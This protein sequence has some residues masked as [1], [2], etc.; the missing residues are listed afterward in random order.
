M[1]APDLPLA[2][3]DL[4]DAELVELDDL[5]AA[6]PEPAMPMEIVM[7][8]G[9]LCGVI[10]QPVL[11]PAEQWLALV[12]DIER[13]AFAQE[14]VG[15]DRI[16]TLVLRRHAALVRA[17][18]ENG[19]FDPL[20]VDDDG[21]EAD[22][23]AARGE[24]GPLA[25]MNAISRPLVPW[26]AGFQTACAAFPALLEMQDEAVM[27]AI[28]RIFRHLP[29]EDQEVREIVDLLDREAPLATLDEAI[30]D[31]VS[32]VA[33]LAD[34]TYNERYRVQTVRRDA[35]KVGRNDPCPC[36]SGRKYKHCHGA[37]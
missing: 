4:S 33:D 32:S 23:D 12:P 22:G 15:A 27:M 28:A 25:A 17:L 21:E 18:H 24:T 6:M 19:W 2:A 10:V 1:P 37:G 14:A 35:P 13:R 3:R 31:L 16:R 7:L 34:L 26:V 9:Y 29:V 20:I 36:G 5:L 11:V 8:D 30:E